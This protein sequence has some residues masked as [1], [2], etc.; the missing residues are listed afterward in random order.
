MGDIPTG[1]LTLIMAAVTA[2][3][4]GVGFIW[5]DKAGEITGLRAECAGLR[6]RIDKLQVEKLAL[7][8]ERLDAATKRRETDERLAGNLEAIQVFLK[9]KLS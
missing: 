7:L 6:D 4:A 1:W 2:L 8:Q 5:K 3:F 9:T